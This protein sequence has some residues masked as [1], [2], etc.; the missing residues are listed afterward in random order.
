VVPRLAGS[1]RFSSGD[2]YGSAVLPLY[3]PPSQEFIISHVAQAKGYFTGVAMMN[4]SPNPAKYTL[5]VFREDGALVGSHAG[6]LKPG[7][8]FAKLV[9]ELVPASAGQIGG[10][11][12]VRSDLRLVGFSLFGTD[13]G[14][15]LSAIPAQDIGDIQ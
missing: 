5:E 8:K 13:D 4:P 15:S 7:E 12:R 1:V 11:I 9:Y 10:Y 6:A 14:L 2:G 3:I